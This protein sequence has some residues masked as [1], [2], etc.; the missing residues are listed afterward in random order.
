MAA[1]SKTRFARSVPRFYEYIVLRYQDIAETNSRTIRHSAGEPVQAAAVCPLLHQV[2]H[3]V[4]F[5]EHGGSTVAAGNGG[6]SVGLQGDCIAL[7][8]SAAAR[9]GR[10]ASVRNVSS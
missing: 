2:P 7:S 10:G 9:E 1:G 5:P 8:G 4:R 6:L 3:A